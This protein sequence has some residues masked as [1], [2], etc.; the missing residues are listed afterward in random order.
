MVSGP[1]AG[2]SLPMLAAVLAIVLLGGLVKGVA[3]FGYAIASTAVLATLLAPTTAV[4][5][6]IVPML[7][8]NL[9]LVRELDRSGLRSCTVR[10]WPFVGSAAVG[11]LVGMALLGRIPPRGVATFL[12]AFTLSYVALKQDRVTVPGETWVRERCFTTRPA[13]K[14]G[15]GLASGVVFGASNVAVQ[16][17][18][19]LDSLDLDRSTFAG[20]LSAILVGISV[21]RIGAAAYLGLFQSDGL[22]AVSVLAA[23]PGVAGVAAGSRL[24]DR[25][26][27]ATVGTAVVALLAVI[28]IRLLAK[29]LLGI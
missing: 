17:V 16:V 19:Y 10:F 7:A 23:L 8:G 28:G 20:V 6:M 26:P 13:A 12:G 11:T 4:V 15:L 21:V 14:V 3:G 27:E 24:R 2:L 22:L 1:I 29:G 5:I 9:S 25:L 18:A